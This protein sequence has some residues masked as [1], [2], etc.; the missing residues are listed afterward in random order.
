MTPG[1]DFAIM[2]QANKQTALQGEDDA[3]HAFAAGYYVA[4]RCSLQAGVKADFCWEGM[5]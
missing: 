2:I 4:P 5:L 1:P 3:S